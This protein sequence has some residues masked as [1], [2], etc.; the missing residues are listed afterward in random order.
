MGLWDKIQAEVD[1]AGAAAKGALDEGKLR[2]E[3]FRV[4][5]Q[6][7]KAAQALGYAVHRAKRDGSELAA[8][9]LEHLHGGLAKHEAEA[10]ALE[11]QLAKA[12]H[13]DVPQDPAPPTDG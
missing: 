6:A 11:E 2:I 5:Q 13:R 10:K 3:L 7:D 4:R 1:K 12:L 9:T 8:E